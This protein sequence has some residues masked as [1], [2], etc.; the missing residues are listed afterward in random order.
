VGTLEVDPAGLKVL[1][2][3]CADLGVDLG[4]LSAPTSSGLS[5]QA[6][7]AAV[8]AVN[9]EVASTTRILMGRLADTAKQLSASAARYVD[10][11]ALS[12]YEIR[13]TQV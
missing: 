6:T 11:D 3:R 8:G 12:G 1:A 13:T 9:G 7:V 2:K 4:S 5:F 10:R